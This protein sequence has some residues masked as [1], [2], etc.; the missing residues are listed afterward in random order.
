MPENWAMTSNV[1]II[2]EPCRSSLFSCN[3]TSRVWPG[4][5]LLS[6]G[7]LGVHLNCPCKLRKP[8]PCNETCI[9]FAFILNLN[10]K[11]IRHLTPGTARIHSSMKGSCCETH[12]INSTVS[13]AWRRNY[14]ELGEF[15]WFQQGICGVSCGESPQQHLNC[16]L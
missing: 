16:K 5:Q 7:K 15:S 2:I 11:K 14:S 1:E 3:I 9:A 6:R 8:P 10:L 4:F 13:E 12:Q